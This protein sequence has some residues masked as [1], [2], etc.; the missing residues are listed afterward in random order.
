M[1]IN[2]KIIN[3]IEGEAKLKIYGEE[4]VDFVE[5]EF[6]NFRG[7]E[8]Y[9]VGKHFLDALVINPRV[10]GIC[11]HS[12]LL[13]TTKAIENAFGITPTRKAEILREITTGLEII[14]NHIKWF[15]ITFMP[16]VI[17]DKSKMLKAISI[18]A[19]A[20]K[21]IALI[22]GQFPHNSYII[23]GGVTCD[24]TNLEILKVEDMLKKL[25]E[26]IVF[27][28]IDEEG[29][30]EDI[31]IF[32]ENIDK[33]IGKGLN[34]FLVL[35]EN[36][37]FESNANVQKVCEVERNVFYDGEFFE[38]GPLARNLANK[39]VKEIYEKYQDSLYSRV[40]A[41]IYEIVLIIDYLLEIIKKI[42][43]CEKNF[44]D[45]KPKNSKGISVIEAP[46]GGLI[47]KIEIENEKIKKYDIIV[48]T[49][50]NLSS[51]TK[52][53]PSPAQ[54]AMMGENVENINV[55]FKCFDICAVC[56]NH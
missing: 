20:S 7:I 41:R 50:F 47:H 32:F 13:A 19:Y 25:K 36:L 27:N 51:N 53:Q 24:L 1:K 44:I 21:I 30:S 11:G 17:S 48:P 4:K 10:C 28:I 29:N 38:V 14:Q 35:G 42:D 6:Y 8:K 56:A 52:E 54:A 34:K 37:Y 26:Y 12:H 49:Q 43:M 5:I 2:E 18:A 31:E 55:I 3:K 39:K 40:F 45:Y 15:Y 22:A 16:E 9:L 33:N 46:R 23:P